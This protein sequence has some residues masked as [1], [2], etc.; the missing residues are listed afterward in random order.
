ML[1]VH[2]RELLAAIVESS[3]DAIISKTT[4]G[5]ITSWNPAA[6]RI[7]GYSSD[8]VLGQ[9]ITMLF[10]EDRLSEEDELLRRIAAGERIRHF[11]TERVR[12]DG[13]RIWVSVTLSPVHDDS[14]EVA[15]ASKIVRDI[16]VRRQLEAAQVEMQALESLG[17][18][19]VTEVF[20]QLPV[21]IAILQGPDHVYEFANPAYREMTGCTDVVGK[22]AGE[23]LPNL[24]DHDIGKALDAAFTSGE[25]ISAHSQRVLVSR[26]PSEP[27]A[28]SFYDFIFQPIRDYRG[29]VEGVAALGFDVSELV[30]AR[31]AA[32]S[33]SQAKDEFLAMLGHELRNP[34][35]PILTAL[36][37]MRLK[38]IETAEAE[39]TVIER[40]VK[41]VVGLVEDLL[42]VS[43]ITRGK[44]EIKKEPVELSEIVTRAIEMASPLLEQHMHELT[45]SVPRSGL[46]VDGDRGRLAQV[47]A[48]LLTNAAKYTDSGGRISIEAR[49]QSG[50]ALLTVRD[51]GIGIDRTILPRIFELFTQE[52]QALDRSKGGLGL[53]LSIVRSFVELHGGTVTAESDGPG[54]GSSF[55]VRLPRAAVPDLRP[56][57]PA[58]RAVTAVDLA[59]TAT[60]VLIVDDNEDLAAMLA[61]SLE[62]CGFRT[63]TA[64]DPAAALALAPAFEPDIAILDL[65][66]PVMDGFELAARFAQD[67]RLQRTRLIALTGYGQDRD[68]TRSS[69]AGFAAHLVKPVDLDHLRITIEELVDGQKPS[70][71]DLPG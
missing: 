44:I 52:R 16:S 6:E 64:L 69:A 62:M 43:R 54:K 56:P 22:A 2:E 9:S 5:I 51:N 35:A 58:T 25:P 68:R 30:R 3:D 21:A 70:R 24:P 31:G 37:L 7:F 28:E 48:N 67:E 17:R 47:V 55:T 66:L 41:H 4:K 42:D 20:A 15:G 1:N 61:T 45:V 50:S 39:R 13:T 19:R 49:A 12:K 63:V 71:A 14:G 8:E 53:G 59:S 33:A 36:Q 10:P 34:L 65:G 23:A 32:E 27:P 57:E 46:V 38:G 18:Q 60:R 29:N 40:Q 11:E 26:A